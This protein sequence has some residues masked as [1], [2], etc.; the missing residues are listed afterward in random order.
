MDR[1]HHRNLGMELVRVTEAAALSAAAFMGTGDKNGGDAAAVQAMRTVLRTVQMQGIVLIGEGEKDEAPMLYNG[2]PVGSGDGP[3]LDI[4]VDPVEGTRLL[5]DGRPN[6]ISVIAAAPKGAMW[7]PGPSLYMKKIV[8]EQAARAAIDIT[9]SPTENLRTIAAALNRQIYNLTVFVLDKPRHKNLIDEI[10]RTGA[11]ITLRSDGDVMG[12]LMAAVPGTGIDVLM[13]TGGTPE[14]IITAAAVKAL[15][16]GMQA[17]PDPQL[18]NEQQALRRQQSGYLDQVL[19]QDTLIRSEDAF[20]AAT[21]IT[22]GPFLEGV[23][24]DQAT[25]VTTHSIVIRALSGSIRYI[26]GIHQR[27][28]EHVFGDQAG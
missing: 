17:M 24:F 10:R 16:G 20:F 11:R 26:Q 23:H 15:G 13:G 5:A 4:A 18:E 22:G 7:D 28:P 14:G 8:V 2:E 12:G 27:K 19:D 21:G 6:A 9:Q 25:G 1:A 3:E